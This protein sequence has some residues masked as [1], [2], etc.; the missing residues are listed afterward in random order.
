M[1]DEREATFSR[2]VE[3]ARQDPAVLGAFV[4]GSRSRV[5]FAEDRSDYDVAVIV[6]D[7]SLE[8]LGFRDRWPYRHGAPVEVVAA[9]LSE[10]RSH[11]EPGAESEW[12]RYQYSHV[13][14]LLDKTGDIRRTLDEKSRIPPE[15]K[16]GIVRTTLDGYINFTYRSMRNRMIGL[17][18]A[19]RLDAAESV[20][21]LLTAIFAVDGRV[22]PFNK[23]VEW[24][25]R[26]HPL[27]EAAW[28]ADRLLPRLD[29]VL[30][31]EL[32]DQQALFRDVDRVGRAHGLADV[33]LAWEPDV[34]WLRGEASYRT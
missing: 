28:S 3:D 34:A 2:L 11:A 17:E 4:F 29:R 15:A 32:E 23:Y 26:E 31:G 8:G 24:E 16:D 12:A 30:T 33:I 25:L 7:G 20:P 21:Y 1:T 13:R 27:A 19:A 9:T 22:R 10:F 5:G 6:R 18:R 14:L